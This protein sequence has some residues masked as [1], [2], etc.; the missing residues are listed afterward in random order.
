MIQLIVSKQVGELLKK[1]S[2]EESCIPFSLVL[3]DERYE[4]ISKSISD[5]RSITSA[6]TNLISA[7][8]ILINLGKK[9]K[10]T[11]CPAEESN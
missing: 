3:K 7:K 11:K 4:L 6:F 5:F 2:E 9:I 10:L 1:M 8:P